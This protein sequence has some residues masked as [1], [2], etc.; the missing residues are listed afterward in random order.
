[1]DTKNI[2]LPNTFRR[3]LNGPKSL[4]ANRHYIPE[5]YK[6][7]AESQE[8]AFTQYILKEMNKSTVNNRE[9]SP[10]EQMFKSWQI[11]EQAKKMSASDSGLNV[12]NVILEE[13][14]P[15]YLR[16]KAQFENYAIQKAQMEQRIL[17]NKFQQ[18]QKHEEDEITIHRKQDENPSQIHGMNS[19]SKLEGATNE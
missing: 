7:A 4:P 10:A 11:E 15:R 19:S 14:Y 6:K 12:K 9:Q 16:N 3:N 13:M 5:D 2:Q 8:R 17:R 1:M 18:I